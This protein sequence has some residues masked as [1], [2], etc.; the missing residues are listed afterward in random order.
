MRG[1]QDPHICTAPDL[2][3]RNP[4]SAWG[5]EG[6]R[7]GVKGRGRGIESREQSSP[8]AHIWTRQPSACRGRSRQLLA[9]LS[10]SAPRLPQLPPATGWAVVYLVFSR[11]PTPSPGS[12]GSLLPQSWRRLPPPPLASL[13]RSNAPNPTQPPATSPASSPDAPSLCFFPP[14][15]GGDPEVHPPLGFYLP[16]SPPP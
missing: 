7:T 5:R 16:G 15:P 2:G 4:T 1:L 3:K 11:A 9:V 14:P 10:G 12:L 13:R 8:P 6:R